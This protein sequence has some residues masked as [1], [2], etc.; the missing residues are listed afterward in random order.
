MKYQSKDRKLGTRQN[1]KMVGDFLD[2]RARTALDVGCDEAMVAVHLHLLGL[3]VDAVEAEP[4]VVVEARNFIASNQAKVNLTERILS[5]DDVR[6]MKS[7]DVICFLSV[8][9]QIVAN[10]GLDYANQFLAE[11]YRKTNLQFFFQPCMIHLKH[12]ARMPFVENNTADALEFFTSILRA[13]GQ[14]VHGQFVGYSLNGLPAADPFR[15]MFLFEKKKSRE[16]FT[17]PAM[18]RGTFPAKP[19]S[20][21]VHIDLEQTVNAHALQ[22]F[23]TSGWHHFTEACV[24]I[25]R[26]RAEPAA[27]EAARRGLDAYYD[28]FQP[29]TTGEAWRR[30]G[31]TADIGL[32]ANQPTAH[33][34]NW[35]PWNQSSDPVELMR[36]G[37]TSGHA[38]PADDCHAYG[39]V[40]SDVRE[41]ELRRLHGLLVKLTTDGYEPEVNA[42]GYL[43]GQIM[44]RGQETRFLLAAG[45]HRLAAL[46]ALGY[47]HVL[48]RFQP[49]VLP[50]I[51]LAR[52][53]EWPQVA[54][55]TY[56]VEQAT[57]IFNA[58]FD[59]T[60]L[61]LRDALRSAPAAA[62][63]SLPPVQGYRTA[64]S[65][66][67][68]W[69]DQYGSLAIAAA[70][71]GVT[72]E[73]DHKLNAIWQHGCD[74]PWVDFSPALLCNN[75]PDAK[76]LPVFVARR[77]QA[78]LLLAAGYSQARAI[79][80]P[81]VYTQA[82]GV[83]RQPRSLLVMPTHTLAGEQ[84]SDRAAF[85]TY[86][87]EIKAVARD[88]ARVTICIHP[89]CRQNGL[90]VKEFSSR[91][92]EIVHGAQNTDRN[93]LPRM[94]TL[95]EQYETVTTNGW[96]SHVAY[97]LAF[98]AKVSIH[99]TQPRRTEADYLRDAT[100][101]ADPAALKQWLSDDTA[102]REREFLAPFL[103]PPAAAVANIECGRALIG[104]DNR[105]ASTE[106]AQLLAA[107]ISTPATAARQARYE[108]RVKA[109]ELV[110]AGSPGEAVKILIRAAKADVASRNPLIIFEGLVQIGED[111]APL[112]PKQAGFLVGEAE[113]IAKANGLTFEDML[114]RVAAA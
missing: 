53:A 33:R 69:S 78:E 102:R 80:L 105:L 23:G 73:A 9:H 61:P 17:M 15:P 67:N 3:E 5:L 83:A 51:D 82:T 95:F 65:A 48:A 16:L 27:L 90:W 96:G 43:R 71:A 14:P 81:I 54:S 74:G 29:A 42:D 106:M 72:L 112:E 38:W 20:R 41:R 101:A 60:G 6:A 46:L 104:W 91:G 111:L 108:A 8:Y 114:A 40:S 109:R 103:V 31:C 26:G 77:E 87:D 49:G 4:H 10:V 58:L 107:V 34:C 18:G 25:S 32:L 1:V 84:P 68:G 44:V 92:F 24:T 66:A 59:A 2:R 75:A 86:A 52:V 76:K 89:S 21:L 12:K 85:E 50:V 7:Y 100:W 88:F 36:E 28:R 113:K 98:G 79:G 110:V 35:L 11:L 99:G 64:A 56:T 19:V 13:S 94:R 47:R 22:H 97:A 39:P 55:G 45:Q 57:N 93:A 30:A 63:V 62:A 37:R 70:H